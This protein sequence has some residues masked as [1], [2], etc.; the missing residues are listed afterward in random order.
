M[1]LPQCHSGAC[2]R[3]CNCF[4]AFNVRMRSHIRTH[5]QIWRYHAEI[6]MRPLK[7]I[8][9]VF[10][11]QI[12]CAPPF[13]NA[14]RIVCP[15]HSSSTQRL[16]LKPEIPTRNSWINF[17]Y[18]TNAFWRHTE[19]DGVATATTDEPKKKRQPNFGI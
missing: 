13:V 14:H 2:M 3:A 5:C 8:N 4:R 11:N 15:L 1:L 19:V 10:Y 6:P 17:T 18:A 7:S 12:L 9:F 16:L